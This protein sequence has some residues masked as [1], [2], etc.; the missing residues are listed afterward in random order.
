VYDL[1]KDILQKVGGISNLASLSALEIRALPG[2]GKSRIGS[3][4]AISQIALRIQ[5][6][7]LN[8]PCLFQTNIP[9]QRSKQLILKSKL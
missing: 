3:L 5:K 4:L 7:K 2:L 6:Q 8:F 1:S 9:T